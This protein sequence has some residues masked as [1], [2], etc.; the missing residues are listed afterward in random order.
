MPTSKLIFNNFHPRMQTIFW[1]IGFTFGKYNQA[2]FGKTQFSHF[3]SQTK[4]LST[5]ENLEA[6]DNCFVL[7]WESQQYASTT[8]HA[9]IETKAFG[10]A[11]KRLTS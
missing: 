8:L 11:R 10:L 1:L 3:K 7:S 9:G 2:D 6:I 5:T 4:C